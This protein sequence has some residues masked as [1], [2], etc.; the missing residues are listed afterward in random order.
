MA[1]EDFEELR[2]WHARQHAVGQGD[3]GGRAR[4]PVDGGEFAEDVAGGHL[5]EDHL[6]AGLGVAADPHRAG[7][8]EEDVRRLVLLAHDLGVLFAGLHGAQAGNLQQLGGLQVLEQ[9]N[10]A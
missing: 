8:D 9:G 4:Q 10:N 3:D 7:E 1:P 6:A 2:R 5:G